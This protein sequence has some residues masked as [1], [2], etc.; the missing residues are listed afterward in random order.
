MFL[1]EIFY[2]SENFFYLIILFLREKKSSQCERVKYHDPKFFLLNTKI[3]S[4]QSL[5]AKLQTMQKKW[6]KK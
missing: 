6:K 4:G 2:V 3:N 5:Y 1:G